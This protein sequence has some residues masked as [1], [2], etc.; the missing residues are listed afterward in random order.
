MENAN[1]DTDSAPLSSD[2]KRRRP[3]AIAA[4]C[5]N[6][7]HFR[8]QAYKSFKKPCEVLGIKAYARPCSHFFPNPF[9]FVKGEKDF[10][11]LS[12]L[13]SKYAKQLPGIV[14]ML[15]G[16]LQSRKRG[17]SFGQPVVVRVIGDDYLL[18]YAQ[19]QVISANKEYVFIQGFHADKPIRLT[20]L[21]ES[22]ILQEDWNRKR[23][24]LITRKKIRD[25]KAKGFYTVT[26]VKTKDYEVPSID[27]FAKIISKK[28]KADN[29]GMK[30]IRL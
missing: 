18:N 19:A 24:A 8:T 13:M 7:L 30:V 15:N 17:F 14:A 6:C 10:K 25:P 21:H 23:K 4:K 26:R 11:I 9:E 1:T 29:L 5:K 16:E 27:D 2:D 3:P 20:L 12:K 22:V 28:K